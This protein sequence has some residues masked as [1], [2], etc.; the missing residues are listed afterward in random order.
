M[1][2]NDVRVFDLADDDQIYD[3]LIIGGG[4]AGLSAGIYAARFGLKTAVV[5]KDLGGLITTTHVVENWPGEIRLS[6]LELAKK[7]EDHLKDYD[8]PVIIDEVTDLAR[9]ADGIFRIKSLEGG[10]SSKSVLLATG[11]AHR[12]LGVPGEEEFNNKGVSY[13]AICDGPLFAGKKVAV[14]GGSDSAAKEAL[15]LSEHASKVY[16]IYRGQ[17]IRPEP[18]N[19]D[20]VTQNKK[21]GIISSTNIVGIFGEKT[22]SKVEL[23]REYGGSKELALQGVFIA[24]GQLPQSALAESLGAKLN[25]RKEVVI[26]R[27]SQTSVEGLF[28]AGDLTDTEFK[29]AITG[30]AEGVTAAWAAFEYV[31]RKYGR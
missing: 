3:F 6:G 4:C 11:S 1:V 20:R 25:A 29:Q 17:K 16:M 18:I 12:K 15:L 27:H 26:D 13:C 5:S 28:A 7:L 19:Y 30:A 23:D 24:I 14:V 9:V 8:V 31:G 10:Y 21:I 2:Q 22:V